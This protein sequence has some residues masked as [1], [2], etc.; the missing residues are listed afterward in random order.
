MSPSNMNFHHPIRSQ[1]LRQMKMGLASRALIAVFSFLAVDA[2]RLAMAQRSTGT[3]TEPAAVLVDVWTSDDIIAAAILP[4]SKILASIDR[5]LT[6]KVRELPSG[7]LLREI[8]S[9]ESD[10]TGALARGAIAALPEGHRIITA[11]SSGIHR[12]WDVQDGTLLREFSIPNFAE[13]KALVVSADGKRAASA[14]ALDGGFVIWELGT[15]QA[16]KR[17]EGHKGK[18]NSLAFS[19][20]DSMIASSGEDAAIRLWE[21]RTGDPVRTLSGLMKDV[22]ALAFFREG[23]EIISASQDGKVSVWNVANGKFLR[24]FLVNREQ[25]SAVI[26]NDKVL[27]SSGKDGMPYQLWDIATG[28]SVGPK[29]KDNTKVEFYFQ[30]NYLIPWVLTPDGQ[31][32]ALFRD[33]AIEVRGLFG[34]DVIYKLDA[35]SALNSVTD[36]IALSPA[37][38][39]LAISA[40]SGQQPRI[41]LWNLNRGTPQRV[42]SDGDKAIS[43]VVFVGGG[44]YLAGVGSDNEIK[45]FDVDTGSIAYRIP[46]ATETKSKRA[47]LDKEDWNTG[48][49]FSPDMRHVVAWRGRS[50]QIRSVDTGQLLVTLQDPSRDVGRVTISPDSKLALIAMGTSSRLV[51]IPSGKTVREL[52]EMKDVS[53]AQF[54]ADGKHVVI[55]VDGSWHTGTVQFAVH[56]IA[57]G[58][59]TL[60]FQKEKVLCW[61][62]RS[63]GDVLLA[64]TNSLYEVDLT[65]GRPL[66]IAGSGGVPDANDCVFSGGGNR[67]ATKE[68]P[69]IGIRSATNSELQVT[70]YQGDGV[71]WLAV[72]PGGAFGSGGLGIEAVTVRRGTEVLS[73]EALRQMFERP[74]LVAEALSGDA[75]G[76]VSDWAR[77]ANLV[78]SGRTGLE[79]GSKADP[80]SRFLGPTIGP[81]P[82]RIVTDGDATIVANQAHVFRVS[83]V[84][85]SSDGLQIAT[86]SSDKLAKLWDVKSGRLIRTFSGADQDLVSVALAPDGSLLAAGDERGMVY[87]WDTLSRNPGPRRLQP[88]TGAKK[89]SA[90]AWSQ[91]RRWLVAGFELDNGSKETQPAPDAAPLLKVWETET[92]TETR[93]LRRQAKAGAVAF[94]PDA[95]HV[96]VRSSRDTERSILIW[97]VT[98]GEI[99]RDFRDEVFLADDE[100]LAVS[101][102]GE[103]LALAGNKSISLFDVHGGLFRTTEEAPALIHGAAFSTDG[104]RIYAAMDNGSIVSW[105]TLSGRMVTATAERKE[106]PPPSVRFM[107]PG[108]EQLVVLQIQVRIID[109]KSG[110]LVKTLGESVHGVE[111][112]AFMPDNVRFVSGGGGS[113][114]LWDLRQAEP[115]RRYGEGNEYVAEVKLSRDAKQLLVGLN[116]RAMKMFDVDSGRTTATMTDSVRALTKS[117]ERSVLRSMLIFQNDVFSRAQAFALSPDGRQAAVGRNDGLVKLYDAVRGQN[118]RTIQAHE[119]FLSFLVY[120]PDGS[121]LVSGGSDQV[122]KLWDP[123]TGRLVQSFTGHR[124]AVRC[125]AFSRDGSRLVTGSGDMTLILWDVRTGVALKAFEGHRNVVRSVAFFPDDKRIVS[126]GYDGSVKIWDLDTGNVIRSLE[127]HTSEVHSVVVSPDGRRIATGSMDGTARIWSAETGDLLASFISAENGE[128]LIITPEGFFQTSPNGSELL[129]VVQGSEVLGIEQL[130]DSLK[131]PDL[132]RE[133]LAGDPLGRVREAAAK[134]D[135]NAVL[136]SGLA[137]QVR[138]VT[139]GGGLPPTDER[140]VVEAEITDSGGGIGRVVWR[141]GGVTLG[142]DEE[143]F[144]PQRATMTASGRK[145]VRL[146]RELWLEPGNNLVEVTATNSKNLVESVPER[147]N[148]TWDGTGARTKPQL[149]VFAAGINGY[150]DSRLGLKFAAPDAAGFGEVLARQKDNELYEN[151]HVV[152]VLDDGVTRERLDAEFV[153]LAGKIRPRDVFVFFLAGHGRT[154][155]GRYY[156]LPRDFR[157]EHAN[158]VI[159]AGIPQAQFQ[160][161]FSKIQARKSVLIYDTCEAGSM[162]T[163]R[164]D[165]RSTDRVQEQ[166]TAIERLTRATGRSILSAA[167]ENGPAL[168]GV[169]GHGVFSYA[170]LQGM[171]HAA[172]DGDGFVRVLSLIKYIDELVPRVS[173]SKFQFRQIPQIPQN[174][175]SG[176][177]FALVKPTIISGGAA[178][179]SQISAQP[180]HITRRTVEV[181]ESPSLESASVRSLQAFSPV[182]LVRTE[183]GWGLVAQGGQLIGYVASQDLGVIQWR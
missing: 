57:T 24:K 37:G 29:N 149:Y 167:T 8:K 33:G 125:A 111:T 64:T 99:Q 178:A 126:G 165:A 12:I 90:L 162:A 88:T 41:R 89:V 9:S 129:Q 30:A 78:G 143:P 61:T 93:T 110:D 85:I 82:R 168:E 19:P 160:A 98:T 72:I 69:G 101:K 81:M 42:L 115:L 95:R 67:L 146:R 58:A 144:P 156:F 134:L 25:S 77:S 131:R 16:V 50:V 60:T 71:D 53:D 136:A 96:A 116:R 70:I 119:G 181:L 175:F 55:A 121:R 27:V 23:R 117:E 171:E 133:K 75:N 172:V 74:D 150:W 21:A 177:D 34:G 43:K 103:T 65:K 153:E 20:D 128:W 174:L 127:G 97:D 169:D 3:L 94:L 130:L 51:E 18:V 140:V 4:G 84:A 68:Q 135:L 66:R 118:Q 151:I 183:A 159:E 152:T 44:R 138:L 155:D 124:W 2:M 163:A 10:F 147:A 45:V 179:P 109:A 36:E 87:V 11:G 102:D 122:A 158:S 32:I 112:V 80:A 17:I 106:D 54:T 176:Q 148:I 180:T 154:V 161:W 6:I 182:T 164:F 26:V 15:G 100:S 56:E 63:D 132:V 35:S 120:T 62:V 1:F 73:R 108:G 40:R 31:N 59:V 76:I 142:V 22:T 104:R 166:T 114:R 86:T 49:S 170:I 139:P 47:A 48:F 137:P 46:T 123:T 91:D 92:W 141:I 14:S 145:G 113:V 39:L 38:E 52:G 83:A 173:E 5:A 7:R 28:K 157:N 79:G 13:I 105:D 107:L